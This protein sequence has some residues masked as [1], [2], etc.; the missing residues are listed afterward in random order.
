MRRFQAGFYVFEYTSYYETVYG[1]LTHF[2]D[3]F[4]NKIYID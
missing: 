3:K 4:A 1:K 2:A